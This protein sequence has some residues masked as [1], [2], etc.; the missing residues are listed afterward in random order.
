MVDADVSFVLK[1]KI[2]QGLYSELIK[3]INPTLLNP[4]SYPLYIVISSSKQ[5]IDI[6]DDPLLNLKI[7]KF[8]A[9][10]IKKLI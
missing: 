5:G 3:S 2:F 9:E 8:V 6:I 7:A 4:N 1:A 10:K